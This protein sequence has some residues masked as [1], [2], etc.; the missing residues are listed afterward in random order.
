MD[1][2]KRGGAGERKRTYNP[3]SSI[4]ESAST[5]PATPSH[6]TFCTRRHTPASTSQSAQCVCLDVS[7]CSLVGVVR[8]S[9]ATPG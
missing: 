5:P 4:R 2:V 6:D 3:Q 8:V 9:L 1:R 7:S